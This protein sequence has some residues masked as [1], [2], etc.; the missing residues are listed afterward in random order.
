LLIRSPA[1]LAL[2]LTGVAFG[3]ADLLEIYDEMDQSPP[4]ADDGW[5]IHY[6][7][8]IVELDGWMLLPVTGK[9]Q[10]PA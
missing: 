2:A 4:I 9:E 1:L 7:S 8:R 10:S 3:D 6:P 5:Q